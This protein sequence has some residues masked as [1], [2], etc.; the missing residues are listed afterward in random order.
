LAELKERLETALGAGYRVEKELGG[1]GMSRVFL[2]EEVRLGRR[3]VVKVLPPEMAAGVS[4]ERFEREIQ[5]AAKLQHPHIV[6]LLTAGSADDLLYYIMPY[7]EGESLRAKLAREGELPVAEALRILRDVLDALSYA[8]G[9]QV[10]HRDIKPDN[11]LLSGKHALVTDFGVAKAVAES[12]GKTVLTSLGVA[13]GTPAYMAPEQ[14]VADPHV[15]HRADV[16]AVGILAY[17]MLS[18]RLPFSASSPQAMLAA[19][20]TEAPEPVTRHRTAVPEALNQVI[21]H[22]LEKKPADR[23]QQIDEVLAQVEAALTPTGGITP[24][25]TQPVVS[26]G[27]AAAI[28]RAHPMRVAGLF[29]LASVGVL[30]IVYAAVRVVGLPDWVS[31]GAIGLLVAGLPIVLVTGRHER[32]RALARSTGHIS[33]TPPGGLARHFT[34]RKAI[35][36]GVVAFAGLAVVAG[37][38]MAM[39]AL[40]IGPAATLRSRGVLTPADTLILVAEFA[41]GAGDS[42]LAATVTTAVRVEFSQSRAFSQVAPNLIS[43]AMQTMKRDAGTPLRGDVAREVAQRLNLKAMVVG[44]VGRLGSAY[45]LSASLISPATGEVYAAVQETAASDAAVVG[46]VDRLAKALRERIGESLR[47]IRASQPLSLATTSSLGAL[48]AYTRSMAAAGRGDTEREV[49]LLEEAIQ[50]DSTFAGAY[51]RLS[52]ALVNGSLDPARA[53]WAA[54]KAFE[55]RNRLPD[56]ERHLVAGFYYQYADY[57]PQRAVDEYRAVLDIFPRAGSAGNNLMEEYNN[58]RRWH[59]AEALGNE[60]VADSSATYWTFF[61]NLLF[62]QLAQGKL[63]DADRTVALLASRAPRDPWVPYFRPMVSSALRKY[64]EADAEL[65]T[66]ATLRPPGSAWELR[67]LSERYPLSRVRGK[68]AAADRYA[69]RAMDLD[70]GRNGT[71][72]LRV[73]ISRAM[74]RLMLLGD[75]AGAGALVR[76][77]LAQ[78]PFDSLQPESRPYL[79][80]IQWLAASGRAADAERLEREYEARVPVEAQKLA[81]DVRDAARAAVAR[82]QGRLQDALAAYRRANAEAVACSICWLAELGQT[83]DLAKQADSAI[84]VFVRA[85]TTPDASRLWTESLWNGPVLKRLGELHEQLGERQKALDSYNQFVELW[86]D[87]DP[88]LQQEVRDVKQ[89]MAKLA[90]E[91]TTGG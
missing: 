21:L 56:V 80:V 65:D 75:T 9:Q 13:L 77:A 24:T 50:L 6:P 49:A 90:G 59:E 87:A 1:G 15:D 40:G 46:A 78:Q 81:P 30:A 73:A 51:R 32:R 11:V 79:D 3:V 7:I 69:S 18:G 83:Y 26:S 37:G 84:A 76:E 86:K 58:Q 52:V 25:A 54:T 48:K 43:L 27:T 12:T 10:V 33:A 64:G 55:Y 36:G 42:L 71:D 89:R 16:Y 29:G 2:A 85:L 57:E 14:A 88:A 47:S 91:K 35:L 70:K 41:N 66:L 74:D 67:E 72:Y 68:L 17:E 23:W 8:H 5:L 28:A 44:E 45:A 34:W 63:R 4:V 22:C 39:R 60:M 31:Y 82:A 20:V 61:A 62:A 19:Q 38:Y 53:R